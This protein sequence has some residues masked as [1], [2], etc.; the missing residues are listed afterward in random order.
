MI[1]SA[2]NKRLSAANRHVSANGYSSQPHAY[3]SQPY[4]S[5]YLSKDLFPA[6]DE[7]NDE[8]NDL[9]MDLYGK[10]EFED[11]FSPEDIRVLRDFVINSALYVEQLENEVCERSDE[12]WEAREHA[13]RIVTGLL[14][15]L[16]QFEMAE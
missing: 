12:F 5:G 16:Y 6:A 14:I 1:N 7:G 3:S 15:D 9:D 4:S 8:N 2:S 13:Y 10:K 11:I